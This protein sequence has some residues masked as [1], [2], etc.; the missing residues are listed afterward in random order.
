MPRV[1]APMEPPKA[2]DFPAIG[3]E[4]PRSE[5][6]GGR[7]TTWRAY[8]GLVGLL[9]GLY[10]IFLVLVHDALCGDSQEAAIR[11]ASSSLGGHEIEI[12]FGLTAVG[13]VCAGLGRRPRTE[14]SLA[15]RKGRAE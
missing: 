5:T 4:G 12:L 14:E 8:I 9:L 13:L 6:L 15:R 7:P 2:M 11:C 1:A 10:T 3:L